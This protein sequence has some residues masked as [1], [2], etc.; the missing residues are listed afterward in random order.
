MAVADI[1]K[2][3]QHQIESLV[4]G[5]DTPSTGTAPLTAGTVT[6]TV[7]TGTAAAANASVAYQIAA[8]VTG[9]KVGDIV[10]I[11]APT[12]ALTGVLAVFANVI[13]NDAIMVTY[14]TSAGFTPTAKTHNYV[15]FRQS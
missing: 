11:S 6:V 13:A 7:P 8:T 2:S 4:L 12:V 1:S 15:V 14:L 3:A 10:H 5:T 9:V